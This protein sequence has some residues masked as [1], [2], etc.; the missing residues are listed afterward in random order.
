MRVPLVW[1]NLTHEKRRTA[2]AVR[3]KIGFIFQRH[4]LFES[5][6]AHQN[7]AM[8]LGATRGRSGRDAHDELRRWDRQIVDFFR[9]RLA[10]LEAGRGPHGERLRGKKAEAKRAGLRAFV[11]DRARISALLNSNTCR[12][13]LARSLLFLLGLEERTGHKPK[14]L[15]GGQRQRVAIA[16]ALVNRP[17]LILAD[18]PTASLDLSDQERQGRCLHRR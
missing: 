6:T 15:S 8:A 7:V 14:A 3:R 4:N 10:D 18:E 1:S 5:L 11:A 13:D 12:N 9:E 17:E 2:V 16:R